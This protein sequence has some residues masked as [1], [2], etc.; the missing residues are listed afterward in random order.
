LLISN[1]NPAVGR[2]ELHLS[3]STDGDV[4]TRMARLAIPSD[5]PSTLQYPQAIEVDG[6]LFLV[7]SRNKGAIELLKVPLSQVD[8]LP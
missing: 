5:K 6:Q 3:V 8:A 7:F 1:A 2:R 4:F